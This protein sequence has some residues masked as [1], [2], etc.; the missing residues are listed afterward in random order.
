MPVYA[1]KGESEEE[2][3]WCIEQ[4]LR[5]PGTWTPNM[6]LDD[7]GDATL[8]VHKGTEF[9][10][11]GAVPDPASADSEEFAIVLALLQRSLS[12][13]PQRWTSIGK[14]VR[15]VTEETTTREHRLYQADWLYRIYGFSLDEVIGSTVD[16]MLDLDV[17]PKLA[18]ALR[19]RDRFPV[20]INKAG[21]E[22]LLR[23][24][25]LGV[26]SVDRILQIRRLTTLRLEDV[27]KLARSTK[28]LENFVSALGWSPG[29]ALDG[30]AL[31][32]VIKAPARQ[33][34]LF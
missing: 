7:G 10:R 2:Y 31:A 23:V 22:D 4:T 12:E 20:D 16:G 26:K 24:P 29:A 34:S 15:G 9:E 32:G 5:G 19:H 8:L 30:A 33:L 6:V 25:G 17:D 27:G 18:W 1:W 14:G 13:D 3:E 21:R 11:A 28:V